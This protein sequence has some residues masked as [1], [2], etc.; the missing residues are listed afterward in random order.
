[1]NRREFTKGL[2]AAGLTAAA[3]MPAIASSAAAANTA[4]DSM[5]IWANFIT[6]VHNK[7]SPEMLSRH[8]RL[9]AAHGARL[10]SQ[11]LAD[12]AISA[13]NAFGIS[14]ATEPLYQ[15]FATVTGHGS[16]AIAKTKDIRDLV[17]D[18]CDEDDE[19]QDMTQEASDAD[20]LADKDA[21]LS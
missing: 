1:M 13:P 16:K 8:L 19:P 7:C 18:I 11:L 12:G 5:Y 14:K 15:Q 21:A 4:K 2:A 9:D 17:E 6:R 10:Y 20:E 3:P